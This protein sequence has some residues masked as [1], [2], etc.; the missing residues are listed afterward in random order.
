MYYVGVW[1]SIATGAV[2]D[3]GD[4][5]RGGDDGVQCKNSWTSGNETFNR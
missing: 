5:G 1:M 3:G 4:G 2:G